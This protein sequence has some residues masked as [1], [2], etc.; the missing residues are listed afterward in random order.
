MSEAF[1]I[2]PID[3]EI[4]VLLGRTSVVGFTMVAVFLA[5]QLRFA[6]GRAAGDACDLS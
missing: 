3:I 5:P 2:D 6:L 1:R 4:F